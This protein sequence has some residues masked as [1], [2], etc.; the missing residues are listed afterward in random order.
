M[1]GGGARVSAACPFDSDP[2]N[3]VLEILSPGKTAHHP[4]RPEKVVRPEGLRSDEGGNYRR[5]PGEGRPPRSSFGRASL[6]VSLRPPLSFPLRPLI[7]ALPSEILPIV[8][9][10]KPRDWP[11]SRSII[12]LTSE[13]VPNGSKSSLSVR[14]VMSKERFTT[15]TI[16]ITTKANP[17]GTTTAP[18]ARR[19]TCIFE[20]NACQRVG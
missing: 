5:D 8:T 18:T 13:T 16:V 11:V 15:T 14:S 12:S 4:R 6:T 10:P 2:A 1:R 3:V 7:A 20:T 9:N 17:T 19:S